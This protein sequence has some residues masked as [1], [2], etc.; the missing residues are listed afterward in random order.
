MSPTYL[1]AL[2]WDLTT[3]YKVTRS[4]K[5]WWPSKSHMNRLLFDQPRLP[6]LT[7][8]V[9]LPTAIKQTFVFCPG[10][11]YWF[12]PCM[13][14]HGPYTATGPP[15]LADEQSNYLDVNAGNLFRVQIVFFCWWLCSR[16][17]LYPARKRQKINLSNFQ[18]IMDFWADNDKNSTIYLTAVTATYTKQAVWPDWAIYWTLGN[19]SKSVATISLHKSPTFL[20]NF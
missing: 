18:W 12:A 1:S 14:W 15:T 6:L 10:P 13:H 20:G 5:M 9:M 2:V 11:M 7:V 3:N 17:F 19:F 4:I 8:V 16:S